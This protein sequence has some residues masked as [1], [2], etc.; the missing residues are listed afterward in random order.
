VIV[1]IIQRIVW[2]FQ[3]YAVFFG[4][5]TGIFAS[6]F[7]VPEESSDWLRLAVGVTI[8]IAV[9]QLLYKDR[10]TA[11]RPKREPNNPFR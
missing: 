8:A 9:S 1:G 4:I 2:L 3:R 10:V 6:R 11:N 7:L 5:F